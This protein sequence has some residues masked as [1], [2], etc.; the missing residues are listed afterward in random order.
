[1][2][3]YAAAAS[4]IRNSTCDRIGI[5]A[6]VDG[7]DA[8]FIHDPLSFYVYPLLAMAGAPIKS[9]RYVNVMNLTAAFSKQDAFTPCLVVCLDCVRAPPKWIEYKDWHSTVFDSIVVFEP[10]V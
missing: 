6:F 4:M 10:K 7:P 8:S 5:D 9:F 1:L 3:A 2:K